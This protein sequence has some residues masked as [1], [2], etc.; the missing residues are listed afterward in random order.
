MSKG[1]DFQQEGSDVSKVPHLHSRL[2]PLHG[3]SLWTHQCTLGIRR[4][5]IFFSHVD[6]WHPRR[7][8]QGEDKSTEAC[9]GALMC[10]AEPMAAHPMEKI[11]SYD[12][13]SGRF[14]CTAGPTRLPK[15][16]ARHKE[17]GIKGWSCG[18][19]IV[20]AT[21]LSHE[22][23]GVIWL[24]IS[25]TCVLPCCSLYCQQMNSHH[26]QGNPE[27]YQND[28]MKRYVQSMLHWK[29]TFFVFS[30]KWWNKWDQQFTLWMKHCLWKF[31]NY[32]KCIAMHVTAC[33]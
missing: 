21:G 15:A 16:T 17:K 1:G 3:V 27:Q 18:D 14:R 33:H 32:V 19:K 23:L 6:V 26:L 22:G 12:M 25:G 2:H 4:A 29:Q 10:C 30:F 11:R 31:C 24:G 20:G 7:G 8:Q 5:T 28:C 13:E 9:L